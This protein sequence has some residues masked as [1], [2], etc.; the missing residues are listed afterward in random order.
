VVSVRLSPHEPLIAIEAEL[1]GERFDGVVIS[2]LART[3][4][5]WLARDVP[6]RV[7]RRHPGLSVISITAPHYFYEDEAVRGERPRGA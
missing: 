6:S 2:T 5:H 3:V 7:R 4:S 1:Q